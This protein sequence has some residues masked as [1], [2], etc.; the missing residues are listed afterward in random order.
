MKL[1]VGDRIRCKQV[2]GERGTMP[3]PCVF[4]TADDSVIEVPHNTIVRTSAGVVVTLVA[5]RHPKSKDTHYGIANADEGHLPFI[6][7]GCIV[8]NCVLEILD[9]P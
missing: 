2:I 4:T 1:E 3:G 9:L 8:G 5:V 6:T 7:N